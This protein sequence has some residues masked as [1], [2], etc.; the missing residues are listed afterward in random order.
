MAPAVAIR[1]EKRSTNDD[2]ANGGIQKP[3]RGPKPKPLAE[4]VKEWKFEKPKR[5]QERSYTRERKIEVIMFLLNHRVPDTR[6]VMPRRR[7]G[8]YDVENEPPVENPDG[9]FTYFR[10]PTYTEASE[11]W[12]IPTAT[13]CSWWDKRETILVGT[14]IELPPKKVYPDAGPPNPRPPKKK[15][16]APNP[17]LEWFK[18]STKPNT[19]LGPAAP[20]RTTPSHQLAAAVGAASRPLASATTTGSPSQPGPA[21]PHMVT[22]PIAQPHS[23]PQSHP[24]SHTQSQPQTQ[25]QAQVRPQQ[26]PQGLTELPPGYHVCY[27]GLLPAGGTYLDHPSKVANWPPPGPGQPQCWVVVFYGP[28]PPP[29]GN[30][31][32]P[33][34]PGGPPLPQQPFPPLKEVPR[35][36][37]HSGPPPMPG[38]A[39]P[40]PPNSHQGSPP[41]QAAPRAEPFP[42]AHA[43]QAQDPSLIPSV[44][45]LGPASPTGGRPI[46]LPAAA[47]P[48]KP[49]PLLPRS[50]AGQPLTQAQ[51]AINVQPFQFPSRIPAQPRLAPVPIPRVAAP[52]VPKPAVVTPGRGRGRPRKTPLPSPVDTSGTAAQPVVLSSSGEGPTTT[53]TPT[54]AAPEVTLSATSPIEEDGLPY[55]TEPMQVAGQP[56]TTVGQDQTESEDQN[57][58]EDTPQV[59]ADRSEVEGGSGESTPYATPQTAPEDI[60]WKQQSEGGSPPFSDAGN[61]DGDVEMTDASQ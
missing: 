59:A 58:N 48:S 16:P 49:V 42:G 43:Y 36:P 4:K 18:Q 2:A 29:Y 28:P 57:Q 8:Q 54:A 39:P 17:P 44:R 52:P 23:R 41:Q 53:P 22:G 40:P 13:I 7:Y 14:G 32:P 35:Q 27:A 55:D 11:W 25:A 33:G 1:K 12:K 50:P 30:F 15:G 45:V 5:R 38:V 21:P 56:S 3:R 9:T 46:A 34:L 47:G 19:E 60:G 24:Q 20:I 6:E 37:H 61:D 26:Q 31:H 51:S 10:A